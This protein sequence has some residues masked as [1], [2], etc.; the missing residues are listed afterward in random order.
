MII[1]DTTGN[2][3][4]GVRQTDVIVI[5]DEEDMCEGCRQTLEMEGLHTRTATDGD[6]GLQLV[7]E[8]GASVVLVDLKM[9]GLDGMDVLSRIPKID[10]SIVTIVIT[11]HGTVDNAVESMKVGA[12]DFLTKPFTP[13]KLLETVRRGMR[14][15]R[16]REESVK[17]EAPPPPA[18][19]APQ[20]AQDI[21]LKGLEVLGDAYALGM[22]RDDFLDELRYLEKEARYHAESL[23]Q[24]KKREKALLDVSV[25]LR[26]VDEIIRVHGCRKNALIQILLDI[27]STFHWIPRYAMPWIAA[28]LNIPLS[29]IFGIATFYEAFSLEPQGAHLV[30]VC[31]G[32]ACHVRGGNEL[33]S[34]VSTILGIGAGETDSKQI[35]TLKTVHCLGCCA[36]APVL[37]IDGR[38]YSNP[39]REQ[40][41]DLL[42]SLAKQEDSLCTA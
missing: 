24:I 38:Y 35:F 14:L 5:D 8:S 9:P 22:K 21:V 27:Q 25:C 13:D 6:Q 1:K 16:L 23:G 32:T 4:P 41:V 3:R 29:R 42:G 34:K 20:T 33:L 15:S 7:E 18:E 26:R 31:L 11:G 39:S 19:A 36:L 12:F 37:Q 17:T 30:H 28:R 2:V 40:L 10:A